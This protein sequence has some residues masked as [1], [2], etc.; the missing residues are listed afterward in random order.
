MLAIVTSYD[1]CD[2][3]L[4]LSKKHVCP[5]PQVLQASK[6]N[7]SLNISDQNSWLPIRQALSTFNWQIPCLYMQLCRV[8][9]LLASVKCGYIS[10]GEKI[11]VHFK[12][13]LPCKEHRLLI[14]CYTVSCPSL[15]KIYFL[16]VFAEQSRSGS[17]LLL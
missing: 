16:L 6:C 17:C 12:L 7:L 1:D 9:K 11:A 14:N 5:E 8:S 13:A 2:I 10:H 4:L 15:F 3:L